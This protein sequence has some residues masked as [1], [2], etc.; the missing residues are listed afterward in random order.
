MAD[1]TIH[2]TCISIRLIWPF[3]VNNLLSCIDVHRQKLNV[4][5]LQKFLYTEPRKQQCQVYFLIGCSYPVLIFANLLFILIVSFVKVLGRSY[6]RKWLFWAS[7]YSEF[8][9]L[10][11]NRFVDCLIWIHKYPDYVRIKLFGNFYDLHSDLT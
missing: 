9:F 1:I 11:K 2:I 3:K 10:L 7:V 8:C 6:F 5:Q 4:M